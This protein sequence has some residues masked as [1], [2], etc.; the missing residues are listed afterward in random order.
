[1]AESD[2]DAI[3]VSDATVGGRE[4]GAPLAE[5][6]ETILEAIRDSTFVICDTTGNRPNCYLELGYALGYG[7][8]V[9]IL[10]RQDSTP[11][12]F[13]IRNR[14]IIFYTGARE[15]RH[16]LL[17]AFRNW[18]VCADQKPHME[19]E[20][21]F[22]RCGLPVFP[23]EGDGRYE[24]RASTLTGPS[25]TVYGLSSCPF[26]PR[27]PWAERFK[28]ALAAQIERA[29]SGGHVLFNGDLLRLCD[30]HP[31]RDERT[32]AHYL[33]LKV[34]PTDYFT[35]V[36]TNYGLDLLPDSQKREVWEHEMQNFGNLRQSLLANPL[37]V[38]I[39][40]VAQHQGRKWILIQERN[41]T[42]V[43][44]HQGRCH[45]SCAGMVTPSRDRHAL[46]IDVYAAARNELAEELGM[47]V[48]DGDLALLGLVRETEHGEVGLIFE[49]NVVEDPDKLL[50]PAPDA[51]E[52][53]RVFSCE[54]TPEKVFS[55]VKEKGG[56]TA[57]SGLAAC[58]V[59]S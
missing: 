2:F 24:Y 45:A 5:I 41:T 51:F 39:S 53:T 55:F 42:K 27:P 1:M 48:A 16:K 4:A 46:G 10:H 19:A 20:G 18:G 17:T 54:L 47:V 37:T 7:K 50:G 57:F 31:V 23:L 52:S 12:E 38:N 14:P 32:R 44:H 3:V 43:F 13:N 35:F 8:Q 30:F 25:V 36:S 34:E 21:F 29:N 15:L 28:C 59:S 6:S 26:S 9:F 11:P 49:A 33:Q 56:F 58:G 22:E 40:A